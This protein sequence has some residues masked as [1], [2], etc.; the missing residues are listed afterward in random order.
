MEIVG[1]VAGGIAACQWSPDSE[2][3]VVITE[4]GN[5][6]MMT[7]MWDVANETPLH[8]MDFGAGILLLVVLLKLLTLLMLY[9][10]CD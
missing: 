7:R 8:Q 2:A 6:L 3:L 10:N 4:T 9:C 1:D 5:I